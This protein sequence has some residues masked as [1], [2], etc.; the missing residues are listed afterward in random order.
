VY[1]EREKGK[2]KEEKQRENKDFFHF[3]QK[4]RKKKNDLSPG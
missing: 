3:F 1:R 4:N 2:G